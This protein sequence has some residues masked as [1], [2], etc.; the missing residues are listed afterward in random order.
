MMRSLKSELPH[1]TN[2]TSVKNS[3]ILLWHC[4]LA[5]KKISLNGMMS[6]LLFQFILASLLSAVFPNTLYD[7]SIQLDSRQLPY[8]NMV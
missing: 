3:C 1:P 8:V 5:G 4:Y 6:G 2:V 7:D